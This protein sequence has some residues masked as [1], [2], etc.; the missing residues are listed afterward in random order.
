MKLMKKAAALLISSALVCPLVQAVP[1][2]ALE[3]VTVDDADPA[4]TYTG[5]QWSGANNAS[6]QHGSTEHFA[7]YRKNPWTA[8]SEPYYEFEFTGTSVAA[9]GNKAPLI[10]TYEVYLDGELAASGTNY[11]ASRATNQ[12]LF[13]LTELAPVKHTLKVVAIENNL[14]LDYLVYTP[15]ELSQGNLTLQAQPASGKVNVAVGFENI[16]LEGA[17]ALTMKVSGARAAGIKASV[18]AEDALVKTTVSGSDLLVVVS[19]PGGLNDALGLSLEVPAGATAEERMLSISEI[20]VANGEGATAVLDPAAIELPAAAAA[21]KTL[22]QAA[23][24]YAH[25]LSEED[26][27]HVN[28]IVLEKFNTALA[29]AEAVL[30][31]EAAS[32]DE[33]K[34]AWMELTYAIHLLD[35]KSD[36]TELNAL[37]AEAEAID[38]NLYKDGAEKDA[39]KA[40]LDAAKKVA[41][42]ETALTDSI[43][44]AIA[45]LQAAMVALQPKE[46]IDTRM[47][48]WLVSETEN[49]DLTLYLEA[50]QDEFK[51]ALASAKAV[52]ENPESQEAVDAATLEL[53]RA[54]ISLR[55]RPDE[56]VLA[57]LK[58]FVALANQFD[59]MLLSEEEGQVIQQFAGTVNAYLESGTLDNDGAKV[60]NAQAQV[61][62]ETMIKA[63]EDNNLP[64]PDLGNPADDNKTGTDQKVDVNGTKTPDESKAPQASTAVD[65][66]VKTA[67]ATGLGLSASAAAGAVVLSAALR[68]KNRKDG[69]EE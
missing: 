35:F 14:H 39:F 3:E 32:E 7:D 54:W 10:G 12:K 53:N 40:A 29:N 37:I 16:A 59:F 9:Y 2:L 55:L 4:I 31:D 64:I 33:V 41:E 15:V 42:S 1:V 11:A 69:S 47:L 62:K 18:A 68:R 8:G 26:L 65:K 19:A 58:S 34:T 45:D 17:N 13:E 52:L 27:A 51:A 23:V 48:A 38:L 21:D 22:L 28:A 6:D 66:S 67:A 56:S 46:E 44:K 25:G 36:K 30:A 43:E 5:A 57:E 49:T 24:D 60:L 61:Y 63:L 50:G 20:T